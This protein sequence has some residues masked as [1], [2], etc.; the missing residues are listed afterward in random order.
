MY[1]F[2]WI[3]FNFWGGKTLPQTLPQLGRRHPLPK[4]YP[5]ICSYGASKLCRLRRS[6]T[7]LFIPKSWIRPCSY[8]SC[9]YNDVIRFDCVLQLLQLKAEMRTQKMELETRVQAA[10]DARRQTTERL[11]ETVTKHQKTIAKQVNATWLLSYY[12]PP[13][14][15]VHVHLS[16]GVFYSRLKTCLFFKYFFIYLAF[17]FHAFISRNLAHWLVTT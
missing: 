11:H 2:E 10:E 17:F 12:C 1:H 7:A 15:V 13:E 5:H 16:H 8:C 3:F 9:S 4:P 14:P 6:T